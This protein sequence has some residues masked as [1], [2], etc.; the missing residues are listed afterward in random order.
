[1]HIDEMRSVPPDLAAVLTGQP[2][3]PPVQPVNNV[4]N[5]PNPTVD[6]ARMPSMPS[7][8]PPQVQEN[9]DQALNSI[10]TDIPQQ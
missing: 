5:Q 3:P 6:G 2:L 7:G 4:P 1:M 8:T 9:Y 10:P